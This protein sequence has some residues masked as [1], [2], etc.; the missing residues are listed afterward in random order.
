MGETQITAS[1]AKY[2][3]R[4]FIVD[5]GRWDPGGGTLLCL[6]RY[7]AFSPFFYLDVVLGQAAE[8][9]TLLENRGRAYAIIWVLVSWICRTPCHQC[10]SSIIEKFLLL[11]KIQ[12]G[13][14]IFN[15]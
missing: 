10:H 8:S 14:N 2:I 5:S 4:Q 13:R 11:T 1:R 7:E 3:Q 15:I 12:N 6:A 9:Q